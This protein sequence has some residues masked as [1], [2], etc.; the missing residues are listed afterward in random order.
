M[1]TIAAY[2]VP[3]VLMVCAAAFLTGGKKDL[4]SVFISGA[5]SGLASGLKLLPTLVLLMSGIRMFTASGALD[6]LVRSAK[7]ISG[8]LRIPSEILPFVLV[9]PLSGS[10]SVVMLK[11]LFSSCGPDSFAGRCASLIAGSTDTILYTVAVYFSFAGI[12]KTRHALP[13]AVL[14]QI[15]CLFVSCWLVSVLF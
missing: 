4:T 3:L 12:K 11:E 6:I 15:F 8:L 14:A 7:G 2:A 10:T 9:R 5:R 1:L 13:C